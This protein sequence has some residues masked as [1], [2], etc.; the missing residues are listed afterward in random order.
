MHETSEPRRFWVLLRAQL[1]LAVAYFATSVLGFVRQTD[2]H[3]DDFADIAYQQYLGTVVTYQL[4][5]IPA[6]LIVGLCYGVLLFPL[7]RDRR[8]LA[9][10]ACGAGGVWA[11]ARLLGTLVLADLAVYI[12]SM[13]PF[14]QRSP[15]LLDGTARKM[16][17]VAPNLDYYALYRLHILDAASVIFGAL[18]IWAA[19]F[20][21]RR[22]WAAVRAARSAQ[23][24]LW[25]APV[26]AL[27]AIGLWSAVPA[28]AP[29]AQAAPGAAAAPLNVLIIASDSLRYDHL[30]VHGYHRQDI[31]PNIDAFAADAVDVRNLHVA[32]ASTLESW[33]SFMSSRF[34]PEHGVRYMYLR[35]D[36][37]EQASR[38]PDMLPRLLQQMGY[39]TT[40]V[41]NW[42]GNCFS[43]V[44]VGFE[45]N[46]A[47]DTQNFESF[48]MEATIWAHL[49][50]PLYFSNDLGAWLLPETNRITK[51]VRPGVLTEKMLGQID[52]AQGEGRPFF[53]LLFYSTT[54]LPY[55][56]SYPY[57]VKYV[58]PAYRG[59]HRYQI[60]VSVHDLITTGFAPDLP[61][62]TIQQ[63]RDLY[64]GAVSEFDHHVGEVIADLKARGLYDR[65]IIIVTS[66]HGEDLYDPGSTL[67]HG[68]NF[69]GGDQSTH[70]PFFVRVPGVTRPGAVVDALARNVDLAPTLMALLGGQRPATWTGADLTPLL[71]GEADDL[72]LPVFA[73][74]CYLFF[75][76]SKALVDL[77]EAERQNLLESKG[78]R[79]TL[80]IDRSFDNNMVLRADL[81]DEVIATKDRMV[82][83]R[84]W[85]LVEI[86]G[87]DGPIHRLYDMRA[88]PTQS[89]DLSRA[90][91]RLRARL[92]ALIDR[93]D[94]GDV[95]K[96]RWP[97][98]WEDPAALPPDADLTRPIP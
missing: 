72:D 49:V 95:A 22:W 35:R 6:Y 19:V 21:A 82:R 46:L 79:D 84:R 17:V 71:T 97:A 37:A 93:Y 98:A 62:D 52:A 30:G 87:I 85:K 83:T 96:V 7:L 68:T 29:T 60:D 41:S 18:V 45:H 58:D 15:G 24:V 63:I 44:D 23:R 2:G 40:V 10:V 16:S 11:H 27:L 1:W 65:T 90:H 4:R 39:Y 25:S 80:E 56:A 26:V 67:G 53:G 86:P 33:V 92:A 31:S 64:D 20:Y 3:G 57:N 73:E 74:T 42:A 89:R 32:T 75:P 36:Q 76:K 14:F 91:P 66:D 78:A 70:I 94:A 13:G 77:T 81:H 48:I 28:G 61:A 47:S 38:L 59:P 34:P 9:Q 43:L 54:H 88:D 12:L 5:V 51:Y 69:F 55:S 50:F 8:A